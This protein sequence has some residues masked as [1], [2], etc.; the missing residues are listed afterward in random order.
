MAVW[1]EKYGQVRI[2]FDG[3]SNGAVAAVLIDKTDRE[4][5]TMFNVETSTFGVQADQIP[6]YI[7]GNHYLDVDNCTFTCYALIEKEDIPNL[8]NAFIQHETLDS[9]GF[10]PNCAKLLYGSLVIHPICRG[11][12][13]TD[14]DIIASRATCTV[15]LEGNMKVD[16]KFNIMLTF[17]LHGD[18]DP[19]S[20]TYGM[21][22]TIGNFY[23][24]PIILTDLTATQTLTEDDDLVLSLTLESGYDDYTSVEWYKDDLLI[25]TS[26]SLTYTITG[27]QVEDSGSY[28]AIVKNNINSTT[29]GTCEV[30]IDY[31]TPVI[32][33]DLPASESITA[34]DDLVFTLELDPTGDDFTS[35]E[36]YKDTV[37]FDTTTSLTYTISSAQVA[38][39]GTYYAI[40]INGTESTTSGSD[41]VTVS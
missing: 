34:G 22:F 16:N 38:D 27:A 14:Y 19:D 13:D 24:T 30:T 33:T 21:P 12:S 39:S 9:I 17:H 11:D 31:S 35:V 2:N 40:I 5:D 26:D 37:L 4:E 15:S 28:Y 3:T 36:W 18:D 1:N 7:F 32:L 20:D 6:G 25:E 41:V 8:T 10:R 29:S 23:T